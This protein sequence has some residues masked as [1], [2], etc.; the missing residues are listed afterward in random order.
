[1]CSIT[2]IIDPGPFYSRV[3]GNTSISCVALTPDKDHPARAVE[4]LLIE[5][6]ICSACGSSPRAREHLRWNT[7]GTSTLR[8]IPACAGAPVLSLIR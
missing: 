7:P 3:G 5:L 4:H 8:F 1:M 2:Q 6:S